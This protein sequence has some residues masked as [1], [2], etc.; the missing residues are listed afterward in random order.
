MGLVVGATF[1][2]ELER[3]RD[4]CPEMTLLIPGI[5]AQGGDLGQA[6][7]Y[8]VDI[9]GEK[10]IFSSSRQILYA[11][12]ESDFA[13]KSRKAAEDLRGRMNEILSELRAG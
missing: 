5:G 7:R 2:D 8:G 11:S 3:V 13:Q 9:S 6:I 1:P 10:A 4:I 12:K